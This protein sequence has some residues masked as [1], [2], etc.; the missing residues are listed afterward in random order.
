MKKLYN[1]FIHCGGKCG[2]TTLKKTFIN[3]NFSAIHAHSNL[4]YKKTFNTKSNIFELMTISSRN[5][6]NIFI[7][8]VYRNPI[9]RKISSFFENIQSH[10]PNYAN[11][12]M[13]ELI[14]FFNNNLLNHIE[15]YHPINEVLTHFNM[16]LFTT[17]DFKKKFIISRKK[18]FVFIKLLFSDIKDW[19]YI[20]SFIFKRKFIIHDA[21]LSKNK[22][23]YKLYELFKKS[24]KVPKSFIVNV[25]VNDPEFKIYNTPEDQDKYIKYWLNKSI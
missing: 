6:N 1:V 4:E 7:I 5:Y 24:Y 16:P 21:N 25:L 17:F 22:A 15:G 18:K 2:S 13:N 23:N 11:M 19:K 20:L 3:N 8:D 14:D 9:E 12:T 10:L